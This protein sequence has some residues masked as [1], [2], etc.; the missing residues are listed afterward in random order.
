[1]HVLDFHCVVLYCAS[2]AGQ[3]LLRDR[4]FK[5]G[6]GGGAERF[7]GPDNFLVRL[8]E[9]DYFLPNCKRKKIFLLQV[10]HKIFFLSIIVIS[11][12]AS[13][14]QRLQDIYFTMFNTDIL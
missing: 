7:L 11:D 12:H 14:K 5:D 1:M 3:S 10:V 4:P 6:E 8:A 2:Q 13:F 9:A